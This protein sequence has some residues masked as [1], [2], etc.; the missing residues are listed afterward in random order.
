[1]RERELVAR[2]VPPFEMLDRLKEISLVPERSGYRAK[3][4]GVLGMSPA[5]VVPS[6]VGVRYERGARQAQLRTGRR[7]RWVR[8]NVD[9]S[10]APASATEADSSKISFPR[11]LITKSS[12]DFALG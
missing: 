8:R 3:A 7:F 11:S 2:G 5:G 12:C 6:A 10:R 9:P 1:M 4:A